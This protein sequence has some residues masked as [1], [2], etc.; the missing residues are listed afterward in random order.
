MR[1]IAVITVSDRVSQGLREDVSGPLAAQ[2]LGDLGSITQQVVVSDDPEE[3]GD[4]IEAAAEDADLVF[5]T[6]GTGLTSRDRTPEA[7]LPLLDQRAYGIENLLRDNPGVPH[8]ALS[9]GLAGVSRRGDQPVF[10]VNA[11]GSPGGVR[12]TVRALQPLL[13]HIYT[14]MHDGD[15]GPAS[16]HAAHQHRTHASQ[17]RGK[18]DGSTADVVLAEVTEQPLEMGDISHAVLD[19]TA[20]AVVTFT[21]V[22]RNHDDGKQ[23]EEIEYEAHPNANQILERIA[24]QVGS[25]S[26]V[27]KIAVVHRTGR[28]K[29]GDIALGI[30]ASAPHR[31]EAFRAVEVLLEE[32]KLQLPMWKSQKFADGTEEWT[33]SE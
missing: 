30:A 29:V 23:V 5:T 18:S 26:G 12:D 32:V 8:A 3:I 1:K 10:I 17:N 15:H 4:A 2:L 25:E 11:P 22:I 19:D 27:R 14:Q 20:G 6:G 16:G 21:G 7:T 31:K 13:P 9:R 28:L 33:G 24:T